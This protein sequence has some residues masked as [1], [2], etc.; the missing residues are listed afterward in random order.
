MNSQPTKTMIF[1]CPRDQSLEA[2][3]A[4]MM[5]AA[6]QIFAEVDVIQLTEAE[7]VAHWEDFWA[8][9]YNDH[10]WFQE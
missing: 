9:K 4:W 3:K 6:R 7:W 2:F 8:K 5:D 1:S 10:D